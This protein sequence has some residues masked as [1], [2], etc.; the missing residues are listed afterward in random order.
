MGGGDE[1]NGRLDESLRPVSSHAIWSIAGIAASRTWRQAWAGV[2]ALA[3]A[4]AGACVEHDGWTHMN[5]GEL[6]WGRTLEGA[7][8][9]GTEWSDA[10]SGVADGPRAPAPCR[11]VGSHR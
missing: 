2:P 5:W 3:V 4:P 11:R 1:K 8:V 9:A 7:R 6:A 10:P